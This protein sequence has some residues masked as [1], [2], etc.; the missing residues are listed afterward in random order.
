MPATDYKYKKSFSFD[1]KRYYV[2]GN[3]LDEVYNKKAMRLSDLKQGK[4]L[5]SGSMSV[6]DWTKICLDT[7]KPNVSESVKQDMSYRI[8]KHILSA[9][10]QTPLKSVTPLQCQQ[11]LSSQAGQSHSHIAK[12]YQELHFIFECARKN[13]YI[14]ENPA[15]GLSVPKGTQGKRRPIT[16]KEREHLLKVAESYEPFK[17]YKLMLFCGCRS[18]EAVHCLGSD[19]SVINDAPML[20]IRGT[21]TSNSDRYVPIPRSFYAEI[22]DTA[23]SR[24][25]APNNR[26]AMHSESSYDRLLARLRREMNI[27]MG[28]TVYRNK[29]YP[30]FPLAEDF[31][32][33]HLRHTYCTDLCKKGIDVRIAQ[34]LMGH[35]SIKITADIYTHVD[36]S[37]L[38]SLDAILD[39]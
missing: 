18:S 1:G 31:V 2:Y 19:I 30:P 14:F 22:K 8:N 17:L 33:Y 11:I 24:P 21:K 37:D 12:L 23:P 15:D 29:L 20:H 4:I 5:M 26:G 39:S 35:A 13:H 10:G 27:S 25:I 3:T 9:I 28:C 7:Y 32:P 34:R 38:T 36:M 6:S 16:D